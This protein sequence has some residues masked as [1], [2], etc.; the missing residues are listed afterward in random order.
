VGVGGWGRASARARA[1]L[2]L[3][4][5]GCV[6][7]VRVRDWCQFC[8]VRMPPHRGRDFAVA[9]GCLGSAGVRA[10]A[11][12]RTPSRR[13]ALTRPGA[14]DLGAAG[15]VDKRPHGTVSRA[16]LSRAEAYGPASPRSPGCSRWCRSL[17][18]RRAAGAQRL[19]G[20]AAVDSVPS[21][22]CANLL[23]RQCRRAPCTP[24]RSG[25]TPRHRPGSAPCSFPVRGART[26]RRSSGMPGRRPQ[27][28]TARARRRS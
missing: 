6:V 24:A 11:G 4:R 5:G 23:K 12:A 14:R 16:G 10:S 1:V 8:G 7:P 9:V 28:A 19:Q 21:P 3:R 22:T 27:G 25:G 13:D 2:V 15:G 26:R 17:E 18:R 20:D